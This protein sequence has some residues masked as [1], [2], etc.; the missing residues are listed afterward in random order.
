MQA[1]TT[2]SNPLSRLSEAVPENLLRTVSMGGRAAGALLGLW[3]AFDQ[4]YDPTQVFTVAVAAVILATLVPLAR[5]WGD[6]AA[7]FG[8][9]LVLFAGTVLTHLAPGVLMLI[10]G[11]GSG[12]AAVAFAQ[13]GNRDATLPALA[14]V[15]AAFFTGPLQAAIVFWFE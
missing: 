9:G 7:G 15:A 12:L 1:A 6:V 5:G 8:G 14:F 4:T 2:P 10:A 3:V 11:A 13:R